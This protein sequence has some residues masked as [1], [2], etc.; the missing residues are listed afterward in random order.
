MSILNLNYLLSLLTLAAMMISPTTGTCSA[1]LKLY[2]GNCVAS[3]PQSYYYS[4][5]EKECKPCSFGCAS[6]TGL[7]ASEC[8]SCVSGFSKMNGGCYCFGQGYYTT[9]SRQAN[10]TCASG[11]PLSIP[12]GFL[13]FTC[14]ASCGN[15]Y[16]LDAQNE[17]TCSACA[18]ECQTCF[19]SSSSECLG[20]ANGYKFVA[21]GQ[22]CFATCGFSNTIPKWC[23]NKDCTSAQFYDPYNL[24]CASGCAAYS[25]LP[26]DFSTPKG[27]CIVC[28]PNCAKCVTEYNSNY[29]YEGCAAGYTPVLRSRTVYNVLAKTINVHSCQPSTTGTIYSSDFGMY[30]KCLSHC[31]SCETQI[32]K[33]KTCASQ[34]RYLTRDGDCI[35]YCPLDSHQSITYNGQ[36]YCFSLDDINIPAITSFNGAAKY[37]IPILTTLNQVIYPFS[38]S[39]FVR[40]IMFNL[41]VSMK[42]LVMNL[43]VSNGAKYAIGNMSIISP[44]IMYP[45]PD[46][47]TS[48]T[49]SYFWASFWPYM[50]NYIV[51][52]PLV[53]IA[54][55][56]NKSKNRIKSKTTE[57]IVTHY[58]DFFLLNF[59]IS[60]TLATMPDL[61]MFMLVEFV[62]MGSAKKSSY[63]FYSLIFNTFYGIAVLSSWFFIL[64]PSVCSAHTAMRT[65]GKLPDKYERI[66]VIYGDI[67]IETQRAMFYF[68]LFFLRAIILIFVTL[69]FQ[70]S[71]GMALIVRIGINGTFLVFQPL[72]RPYRSLRR[73]V[74]YFLYD[75]VLVSFDIICYLNTKSL[76]FLSDFENVEFKTTYASMFVACLYVMMSGQIA[77]SVFELLSPFFKTSKKIYPSNN[78]Q[79]SNADGPQ[80]QTEP[81]VRPRDIQLLQDLP[82]GPSQTEGFRN[83]PPTVYND[84]TGLA[85]QNNNNQGSD[86]EDQTPARES[87]SRDEPSE[88][89][90]EDIPGRPV[91]ESV[92]RDFSNNR[93]LKD[94]HNVEQDGDRLVDDNVPRELQGRKPTKVP[95]NKHY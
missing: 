20:C 12:G 62:G 87:S 17:Y 45:V 85:H 2:E 22:Y 55:F 88:D 60:F 41:M 73:A 77:F 29:C 27:Q 50:M 59:P 94:S 83:Q 26:I 92:M 6:C 33:C 16:F 84:S 18:T 48:K 79:N 37:V 11:Y 89:Q 52:A 30:V 61:I 43:D 36:K 4:P 72:L 9:S 78:T 58:C 10:N 80:R 74:E 54:Y 42:Y 90:L 46:E 23:A 56:L 14:Q 7:K 44:T 38:S 67:K 47:F 39:G 65:V 15:K 69:A 64:L 81:A 51:M 70:G 5:Y 71:P 75:L 95:T 68:F 76:S 8:T 24:T 19:G 13:C 93:G 32:E 57:T 28:H 21:Q 82:S 31:S 86:A 66:R 34:N 91:G 25:L 35:D 1:G 40:P 63:F 3:C 53:I 49:Q